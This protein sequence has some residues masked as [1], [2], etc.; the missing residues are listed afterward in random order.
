MNFPNGLT[1]LS[2]INP[3]V[4]FRS[5][6]IYFFLV[7]FCLVVWVVRDITNRTHSIIFQVFSI[8]L[9]L[10]LTP[11]GI[12]VYL[13]LRPQKTLFEQVFEAEFLRLDS[14]YQKEG[15]NHKKSHTGM[16]ITHKK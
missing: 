12:F 10:F 3:D 9:V 8:L 15:E 1:F 16:D 6:I 13:L 7:W 11:L 14:E 4:L 5:V 2:L